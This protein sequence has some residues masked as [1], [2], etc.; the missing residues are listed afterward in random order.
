MEVTKKGTK[1]CH[2]DTKRAFVALSFRVLFY[3][4]SVILWTRQFCASPV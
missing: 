2:E 4:F 1:E 3:R